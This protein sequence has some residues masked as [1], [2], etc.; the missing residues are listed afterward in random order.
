MRTLLRCI[1]LTLMLAFSAQAQIPRSISYQGIL[2]DTLGAPR[3]DGAYTMTFRLYLSSSGGSAIWS[4]SKSLQL[5]GGLFSTSLGDGTPFPGSLLFNTQYW[6]SVQVGAGTELAPR[7]AMTATP[8]SLYSEKADSARIAGGVGPNAVT[9]SA[10]ADNAVTSAKIQNGTIQFQD[11]AQNGAATGQVMKWNGTAWTAGN[12]SVGAGGGS[13]QWTTSGSNIYYNTGN[14]GIGVASPNMK[15][16]VHSVSGGGNFQLTSAS[17]GVAATDGFVITNDG[18]TAVN[19]AQ[20][21]NGDMILAV[22]GLVNLALKPNGSVGIGTLS[23]SF[24]LDV[25]GIINATD[26]YKNGSPLSTSQ[27]ATN[28]SNIYYNGGNVGIGTSNPTLLT[29]GSGKFLSIDDALSPGIAFTSTAVGGNQYF[30]Y[31][32]SEG[33]AGSG[34]FA[35][36]DATHNAHRFVIDNSGKVGIGNL[37]PSYMLDVN[38]IVN[39]TEI[40]KNGSPLS[41]SQWTTNGSNIYYNSGNV[42]IGTAVP[43]QKLDVQGS[44]NIMADSSYRINNVKMLSGIPSFPYTSIFAGADAGLHSQGVGNTAIGGDA[45]YSNTGS[46]NTASGFRALYSNTGEENV[47]TGMWALRFNATGNGNT[48][49]GTWALFENQAG[50]NATAVGYSAMRYA[51][52]TATPF[53]NFNVAVGYEALR[54]STSPAS[55]TGNYNTALGYQALYSNTT[56]NWNTAIGVVALST[57]STGS[58][59]T[60]NGRAALFSNSTGAYNTASGMEALFYNSTGTD[61]TALGFRASQNTST[62]WQNTSLGSNSLVANTTGSYNTAIGY[63]TGPNAANLF[64]TTCIGIDATATASDMVRIGN[65]FVNSIG[66]QVGWTTLSDERFKENVKEDVPG[67]SFISKLRPVT[68]RVNRERVSSFLGVNERRARLAAEDA[69]APPPQ[70]N[71]SAEVMTGFIAQEVEE[72]ARSVGFDFSGVDAPKNEKDMYGLRYAEFVVPLVKA[73][74]EQ[75]RMIQELKKRIEELEKR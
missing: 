56:G 22:N 44:I 68:Y 50:N 10:I 8:Y 71:R 74:Q 73:V 47:A 30:L 7:I 55:N 51:N 12:D 14:V 13:S 26:I 45:L 9:T 61:N 32:R 20:Q 70:S 21:E 48:A 37:S 4:E 63:N 42:G 18:G 41:T 60:A 6:L 72:A 62:G 35:V 11:I 34:R 66:G 59:N 19:L 67:L 31:S 23:P 16:Q 64:N 2:T 69:S 54:G 38:G 1:P 39:A 25:A 75:Q 57:N 29:G 43:A 40:Y 15:L 53:T 28:G 5:K 3:P 58:Q 52:N 46:Y 65:V 17:T 27:W 49:N 24:K 33:S 36:F